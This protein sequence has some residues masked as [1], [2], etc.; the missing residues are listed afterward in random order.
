MAI[1]KKLHSNPQAVEFENSNIPAADYF[2]NL[3]QVAYIKSTIDDKA[4]L[5]FT[6][7]DMIFVDQSASEILEG[8][9]ITKVKDI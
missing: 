8:Q 2:V 7:G 9:A 1:W 3:D 4:S 5:H 6:S